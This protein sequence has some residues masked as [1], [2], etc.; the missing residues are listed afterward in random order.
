MQV[1]RTKVRMLGRMVAEVQEKNMSG[2]FVVRNASPAN[3]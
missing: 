1:I 3:F 2:I